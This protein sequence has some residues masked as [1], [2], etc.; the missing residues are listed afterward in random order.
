[1]PDI[2]DRIEKQVHLKASPSRVWRAITDTKE[3]GA[4]FGCNLQGPWVLNVPV[5]AT[6]DEPITQEMMDKAAA[7]VGVKMPPIKDN[8]TKETFGTAVVI[9]P[10]TRFAFRCIPFGVEADVDPATAVTTL[11]EFVLEPK[12]GG[13]RL[14]ISESGFDQVPVERRARSF[15]MNDH[16]WTIQADN[17]AKH[18]SA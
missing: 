6:Y 17:I 14:T 4:W 11:V 3:F 16:G 1:M 13:T 2:T 8:M 7:A 5:I 9:E 18:V 12:D 10:E 15:L